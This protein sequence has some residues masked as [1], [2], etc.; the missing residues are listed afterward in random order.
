MN[1]MA[2]TYKGIE[3]LRNSDSVE[4]INAEIFKNIPVTK[5]DLKKQGVFIFGVGKLGQ[6]VFDFLTSVNIEV[7]AFVDNNADKQKSLFNKLPVVSST[8]LKNDAIVYI[9]SATYFNPIYKQLLKQGLLK[10]ISH[11]QTG[12]LFY[13]EKDF[14]VEM[15]QQNLTDDLFAN[16]NKYLEVFQLLEDDESRRVFDNILLFRLSLD[17]R[18]IDEIHTQISKEYF[19]STVIALG[20]DE[21]YFDVGGFD[22]DSAENFVKFVDGK[23]KGVHIFEPDRGL[24][25]KAKTRLK[26]YNNIVYNPLGIYDKKT[27]LYFDVTGG[28]DGIISNQGTVSIETTTI[29]EYKTA[30][31]TY[32]KFDVEGVEIEAINGSV[33]TIKNTKPKMAIASYHYPKHIWQIPLLVKELNPAYKLK[34]RHYTD[35]VFDSIFYF[36]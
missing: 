18:F 2:M 4:S 33:S 28:L 25:D 13:G 16:K 10:L 32:I 31:P 29:D 15:Y 14:P 1:S 17:Q 35:S 30:V 8:T 9:A 5:D 34:L 24:L 12:I 21:V 20:Q 27:T 3:K 23:Y 7:H 19:D 36:S 26:N 6:R 22:G 11:V